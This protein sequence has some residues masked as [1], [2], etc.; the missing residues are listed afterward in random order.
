MLQN[1]VVHAACVETLGKLSVISDEVYNY[2]F[3]NDI[4]SITRKPFFKLKRSV[5]EYYDF[6]YEFSIAKP[7]YDEKLFELF[8]TAL[9]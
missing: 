3:D 2:Y 1:T 4:K 6:V 7:S 9:Q 5:I 8:K